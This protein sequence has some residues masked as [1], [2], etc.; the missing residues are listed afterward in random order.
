VERER[1]A[2]IAEPPQL[3]RGV[4]LPAERVGE[5]AFWPPPERLDVAAMVPP[6]MAKREAAI[7]SEALEATQ[8]ASR[9][10]EANRLSRGARRKILA[11]SWG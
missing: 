7:A 11:G 5:A 9:L 4:R 1:G 2:W 8:I 10:E 6:E 3:Q